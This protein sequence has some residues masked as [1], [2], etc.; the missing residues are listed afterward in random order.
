M[1]KPMKPLSCIVVL[2]ALFALAFAEKPA[3]C[4]SL[5]PARAPLHQN[6]K[7][8]TGPEDQASST[9]QEA[10]GG[11]KARTNKITQ[12]L[13][14]KGE[15]GVHVTL[16]ADG[17]I[18]DYKSFELKKPPR[19]VIDISNV[20]KAYPKNLIQVDHP[21]LK[22]VRL[23]EYS[24]KTRFV[25]DVARPQMPQFQING[26]EG[27]LLVSFVRAEKV[28]PKIEELGT[29]TGIDFKQMDHKS[30]IVVSTSDVATYDVF[31][32][33]DTAVALDLKKTRVP[34]KLKRGVDT[35]AFNSAVDYINLYNVKSETSR[36]VRIIVRL[37]EGVD[38]EAIQKGKRIYLDFEKPAKPIGPGKA[39]KSAEAPESK[40]P[41]EKAAEDEL[42]K[43]L[44][45]LEKEEEEVVTIRD[46]IW[47]W[48]R[49]MYHFNDKL[50]FWLLKPV[51]RGYR[52]AV[53]ERGRIWVRNFFRNLTMPIRA[54]NSALQG[55]GKK[56]ADE[57]ASFLVNTTWGILGFGDPAKNRLNIK[58]HD[59]DFGQTLQVYRMGNGFYIVWP[60]FGPST[61]P[62]SIGLVG[63][64]FLNPVT[65]V[66]PWE[67][68]LGITAYKTVNDTS[69]KIGDY[70]SLKE[71]A[72]DPYIAIRDGYIQYRKKK[73]E[74]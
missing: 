22:R 14:K 48:N 69:L 36:D 21:L 70:E 49:A 23:G 47:P 51:A 34:R 7:T 60:I 4:S 55:K 30:R 73:V 37:R 65:Y 10:V 11:E 67:A 3:Q 62:D 19:L 9:S 52:F 26:A 39:Q 18:G 58:K 15:K 71:A 28:P 63:D 35:R 20:K 56:T 68:S 5:P 57:I 45:L 50:Y 74:E 41:K 32:M 29:L 40:E 38:F 24:K 33:V 42:E 1:K 44:E 2:V 13:V 61:I 6:H 8:I 54:V 43:E 64:R 53:P 12:I 31:K 59:E 27:N 66:Q 16:I 72:V 25:F 17:K 46:P